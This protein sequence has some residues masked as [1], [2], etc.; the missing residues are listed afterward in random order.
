MNTGIP[1]TAYADDLSYVPV[2]LND[3][4]AK[5]F[6]V[7]EAVGGNVREYISSRYETTDIHK[8]LHRMPTAFFERLGT[9]L[10]AK[11]MLSCPYALDSSTEE[12]LNAIPSFELIRKISSS[13]WRWGTRRAKWNEIVD[14]WNGIRSFDL[15]IEG[16]D[17][18]LDY[19]TWYNPCGNSKH[20]RTYLDGVFGFLVHWKGQHVMTIGFSIVD[21]RRL[22][23]QQVQAVNPTG[24]RW[25]FRLPANRMEFVIDR[26]MAA[27]PRHTLMIADGADYAQRS[28]DSYRN[29]LE[30]SARRLDQSNG[31]SPEYADRLQKE[32]KAFSEK[33][34]GLEQDID[35]IAALYR[36]IGRY[37][38]GDEF[39]TNGMRHY[40]LAA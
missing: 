32:V 39:K 18:T 10:G 28:L 8:V 33:I 15:G 6:D 9:D 38:L 17:V 19:S 16:F 22:L 23:L 14:A 11:A 35:R 2:H 20:T 24:N 7:L 26:L 30:S 34:A 31:G 3:T 5:A 1:L 12:E 21:G 13:M 36:N 29:G 27:F 25:M 4:P 40:K 37:T